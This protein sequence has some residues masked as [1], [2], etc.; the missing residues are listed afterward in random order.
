MQAEAEQA[1]QFV[2]VEH[3]VHVAIVAA[4]PLYPSIQ[5]VQ[6]VLLLHIAQLVI[7]VHPVP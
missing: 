6:T 7:V 5:A 3:E 4:S 2:G 1:P